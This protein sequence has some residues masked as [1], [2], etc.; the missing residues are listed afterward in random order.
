MKRKSDLQGSDY[1][2]VKKLLFGFMAIFL[3]S[4]ANVIGIDAY[5]SVKS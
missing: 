1:S 3:L 4:A 5:A 2:L